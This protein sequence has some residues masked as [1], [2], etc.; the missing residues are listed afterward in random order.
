M[1]EAPCADKQEK[2]LLTNVDDGQKQSTSELSTQPSMNNQ[3][4][5]QAGR[6]S[7]HVAVV[8]GML[9]VVTVVATPTAE[10]VEAAGELVEAAG[11]LVA[12]GDVVDWASHLVQM[13]FVVVN[14]R[15]DVDVETWMLVPFALVWVRVTGHRV[16][17]VST[18]TVVITSTTLDEGV[19]D[20]TTT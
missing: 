10:L 19:G 18:T 7:G 17:V 13:V 14:K 16:V 2:T 20:E 4:L 6:T 5:R 1:S 3:V 12:S 8:T 11:E 9:E 15:V